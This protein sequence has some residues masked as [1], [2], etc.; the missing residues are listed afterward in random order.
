MIYINGPDGRKSTENDYLICLTSLIDDRCSMIGRLLDI[1]H[2]PQQVCSGTA[3]LTAFI[4]I[5][6]RNIMEV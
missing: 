5:L 1:C 2:L 4:R 3:H 6:S